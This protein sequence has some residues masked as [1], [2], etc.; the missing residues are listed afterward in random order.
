MGKLWK[1]LTLKKL[2]HKFKRTNY[3]GLIDL[4]AQ[5]SLIK[6]VHIIPVRIIYL[7]RI[8]TNLKV[9]NLK[10]KEIVITANYLQH[11][12]LKPDIKNLIKMKMKIL[13]AMRRSLSQKINLNQETLQTMT[14]ERDS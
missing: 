1:I 3:R 9:F 14:K 4:E 7:N 5:H 8:V 12:K 2:N 6:K 13:L 11:P 10:I